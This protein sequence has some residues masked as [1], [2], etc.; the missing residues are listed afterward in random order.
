MRLPRGHAMKNWPICSWTG[1]IVRVCEARVQ[2]APVTCLPALSFT[3]VFSRSLSLFTLFLLHWPQ[4]LF[5]LHRSL[6][7]SL[8]GWFLLFLYYFHGW[9]HKKTVFLLETKAALWTLPIASQN[10]GQGDNSVFCLCVSLGCCFFDCGCRFEKD[11]MPQH[12]NF[13]K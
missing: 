5:S 11:C 2:P 6:S 3:M 1:I 10:L 12:N 9:K 8:F 13:L 7:A 4:G